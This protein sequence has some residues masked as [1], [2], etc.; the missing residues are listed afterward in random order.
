MSITKRSDLVLFPAKLSTLRSIAF[1]LQRWKHTSP[2]ENEDLVPK[3]VEARSAQEAGLC[4]PSSWRTYD[5]RQVGINKSAISQPAWGI[6]RCLQRKGFEA[7]LVGG[8]VRDLLLKR[9]PKDFDII[10]TAT[11][12]QIKKQFRRCIVVGRRFPICQVHMVGSITEVSSFHTAIKDVEEGREGFLCKALH[13]CS[14]KDIVRWKDSMRRDFTINGLFFDPVKSRV[15]DYVNGLKD[16]R[17]SKVTTVVS[18]HLSFSEDCARILRG[19]RI[20]ARLGFRFSQETAAALKKLSSSVSTL[21]KQRLLMELD[22]M[23]AYGAAG[24][25]IQLLKKYGLLEILLPFH[26]AY[27]DHQGKHNTDSTSTLFMKLFS[28][29][30]MLLSPD[31]PCNCTLWLGMLAF[32]IAL[33]RNPQE[34]SVVWAFS[35]FLYFGTWSEAME[36]V[37]Q[38]DG[39]KKAVDFLPEIK[40]LC[41]AKPMSENMLKEKMLNFALLVRSSVDVFLCEESFQEYLTVFPEAPEYSGKVLISTKKRDEVAEL[42]SNL[43]DNKRRDNYDIDYKLLKKGDPDEV[44]F[45][46]GKVI[47][48]TVSARIEDNVVKT[49]PLLKNKEK[50]MGSKNS[51]SSIRNLR[52]QFLPT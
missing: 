13:T 48:D 43:N 46:I 44:R 47:M 31:R 51:N 27:L 42:F 28:S 24:R 23:L 35:S 52:L 11:N 50:G 18:A 1:Q 3:Q 30:D 26:A 8:C 22:F 38:L 41:E 7:Y 32:H 14:E 9:V 21:T 45:V 34:A 39:N 16:L 25:S 40:A 19:L 4:N 36:F 12:K 5:S 2:G 29:L 15:Y 20:A 6:I 49:Q 17:S 10:T 33:V 37:K